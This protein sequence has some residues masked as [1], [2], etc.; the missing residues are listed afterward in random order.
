M[1]I[2][3]SKKLKSLFKRKKREL[4]RF[5]LSDIEIDKKSLTSHKIIEILKKQSKTFQDIQILKY[6]CLNKTKLPNKFI[7]DNV[8][9]TLYD[10]ILITSLSTAIYQKIENPNTVI[11]KAGKSSEYFYIIL[12]G[13]AKIYRV[14]KIIQEMTGYEYFSLLLKYRKEKDL[15]LLQKTIEENK[16]IIFIDI[17]DIDIIDK[18]VLRIFLNKQ[19]NRSQINYLETILDQVGLKLKDFNLQSYVET[20]KQKNK[21]KLDLYDLNDNSLDDDKISEYRELKIYDNEEA[22][23][24]ALKNEKIIL[25]EL[26]NIDIS[27][28]K[29]YFAL[30][31]LQPT[32]LTYYHYVEYK[33]IEE[34]DYFGDSESD[35]LYKE[36]I[37]S[38]GPNLELMLIKNDLYSEFVDK[39]KVN[40]TVEQLN[41]LLDNFYFKSIFKGYFEKTF[42]KFFELIKYKN[43]QVLIQENSPVEYC[44]YIKSGSVKLTANKSIMENHILIEIIKNILK[45]DKS[46]KNYLKTFPEITKAYS[47]INNNIELYE[48]DLYKKKIHDIMT[49]EENKCIGSECFF[50]GLNNLFTVTTT[51][52]INQ[53]YRI[54]SENLMKIFK[55]KNKKAYSD[56]YKHSEQTLRLFLERLIKMNNMLFNYIDIKKDKVFNIFEEISKRG[57]STK[58]SQIPASY[59]NSVNKL[60]KYFEDESKND[61][62]ETTKNENDFFITR[63]PNSSTNKSK[64]IKKKSNIIENLK[65]ARRSSSNFISTTKNTQNTGIFPHNIEF[66]SALENSLETLNNSKEKKDLTSYI[67]I[68]DYKANLIKQKE[69]EFQR[70]NRALERL[71]QFEKN[72]IQKLKIESKTCKNFYKMTFGNNRNFIDIGNKTFY[73]NNM[74]AFK[75]NFTNFDSVNSRNQMHNYNIFVKRKTMQTSAY[76]NQISDFFDNYSKVKGFQYDSTKS[77]LANKKKYEYAIF[78]NLRNKNM[79]IKKRLKSCSEFTKFHGFNSID[80]VNM[81]NKEKK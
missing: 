15:Y 51:S 67:K 42:F 16:N 64:I 36:K 27:L 17:A 75:N 31:N 1:N 8:E 57:L 52:N 65:K 29:K 74:N 69:S 35:K 66:N 63:E 28:I 48:S 56:F 72:V 39:I 58:N 10:V 4:E 80:V 43:G 44:Y 62:K 77:L 55:D 21:S 76:K 37:I 2:N 7:E 18:I 38:I 6:F 14:E 41:F 34:H 79:K 26:N 71:K 46:Y 25:E 23:N 49:F 5:G 45:G 68:F 50:F 78:D 54:S 40:L 3:I 12:E 53:I 33:T 13:R 24:H 22:W 9:Q 19:G 61:I 32:L 47:Q 60:K 70:A 30:P 81:S 11:Y 73:N 59:K 20:I